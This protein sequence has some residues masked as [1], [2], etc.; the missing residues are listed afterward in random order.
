VVIERVDGLGGWFWMVMQGQ[1]PKR[2][3]D[4]DYKFSKKIHINSGFSLKDF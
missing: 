3:H 1:S 2:P 4:S